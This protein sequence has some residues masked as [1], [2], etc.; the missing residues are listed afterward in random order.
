MI[1]NREVLGKGFK[2]PFRIGGDSLSHDGPEQSKYEEHVL[3]R[4]KLNLLSRY[5]SRRYQRHLGNRIHEL[6]FEDLVRSPGLARELVED[7]FEQEP[8]VQIE[9]INAQADRNRSI[10][11]VY[12]DVYFIATSQKANLVFPFYKGNQDRPSIKEV[13]VEYE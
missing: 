3:D 11:F 4:V 9:S 5:K 1:L 7:A 13:Q 6:P 12:V 10:L 8:M 2:F